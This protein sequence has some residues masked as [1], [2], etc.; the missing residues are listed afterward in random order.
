MRYTSFIALFL[1]CVLGGVYWY[2]STAY[3]CPVPLEYRLGELDPSFGLSREAAISHIAVA[4]NLWEEAVDRELFV[5]SD[6]ADFTIDFVFDE[7]QETANDEVSERRALDEQRAQNNL[8]IATVEELQREY[9]SLTTSYEERVSAYE[10][11]LA[12]YNETVTRYNDR[13]G[14]PPDAFAE[15]ENTRLELNEE[16][17]ALE[18]TARELN[19]LAAEI[20]RLGVRGQRL[21]EE[22]NQAVDAYNEQYGFSREFTQGDYQGGQINIYT[23]STTVELETVLA[24]EFGHALGIGHVD[25]PSALMYYLLEEPDVAAT[26]EDQDLQAYFEVC[27]HEETTGQRI[28]HLIRQI[29]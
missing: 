22:Y 27:G 14:A 12:A 16:S 13:G 24:H 19:E 6:E 10:Q 1:A 4:E 7:R 11:G 8:V 20:G 28:R 25:E 18:Q 17:A 15:L 21:V 23:F 3:M 5:Y 26:L 2:Q 9:D 29:L